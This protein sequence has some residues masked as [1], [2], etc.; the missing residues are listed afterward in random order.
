MKNQD[1]EI[2]ENFGNKL[3]VRVCGICVIGGKVL[4]IKHL[5]VGEKYLWAPPGGGLD[6]GETT[7]EALKREFLEETGLK[8]VV[9]KFLFVHEFLAKPLHGI[10]LFFEVQPEGGAIGKGID[11]EL[12]REQQIIDKVELLSFEEIL[13]EPKNCVHH[14]FTKC[15]SI[16]GL[17][18]LSGHYSFIPE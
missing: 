5:S 18:S 3:R 2:I 1:K 14:I 9:K 13:E 8:V 11:P 16:S 12:E 10:E 4:M 7:E 6:Y 17:L 15:N